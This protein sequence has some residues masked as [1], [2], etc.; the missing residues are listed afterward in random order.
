MKIIGPV[1]RK[2]VACYLYYSV[3]KSFY[4]GYVRHNL[5]FYPIYN[6]SRNAEYTVCLQQPTPTNR[7]AHFEMPLSV[8]PQISWHIYLSARVAC[9]LRFRHDSSSRA[10]RQD[11][12][13][14]HQISPRAHALRRAAI[15]SSS[16]VNSE[17]KRACE[18]RYPAAY[19]G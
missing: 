10:G 16:R 4:I 11:N 13:L 15:D 5:Y 12:L 3:V 8:F 6:N 18:N 17:K 1:V 19:N 2:S 14:P 7:A 9:A